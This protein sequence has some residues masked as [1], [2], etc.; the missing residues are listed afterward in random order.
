MKIVY[1]SNFINHYQIPLSDELYKLT[2]GHYWFIETQQMPDSFKKSGFP[3][4]DRPYI[5][6]AWESKQ[7][8]ERSFVLAV[9]ADVMIAGGGKYILP[10]ERKRLF[11]DKF[12]LEYGERPLKRGWINAFSPTNILT[13]LH[14]HLFFYHKPFYKL[15]VSAYTAND[16]YLQHSFK[17]RC[18]K[19]AYFPSIP[20]QDAEGILKK[21]QQGQK[22]R[23]I[24]CARFIPWKHPEMVVLLADKLRYAGYEFEINMI[25]SGELHEEIKKLIETKHLT[26]YVHLLG[27]FPNAEVME[28]MAEH[29]IFLFTS[30]KREGWGVV[31][32]EAMGQV[33]CP[34]ASH[35][36]G[37]VPFLLKDGE[38]GMV[39]ESCNLDSL[40]KKVCYLLDHPE[41]MQSMSKAAYHT[42]YQVWNPI[43]G[44]HRLYDFCRSFLEGKPQVYDEG[45][46]SR[47]F[48]MPTHL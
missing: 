48:P 21:K 4:Y 2:D 25:G 19:F 9:N 45:P 34:V 46:L 7:V 14:Y 24:W 23:L 26:E 33:C 31:L 1:V 30:D 12:T 44:A 10:Y 18:L 6:K 42:V 17:D 40:F 47:A 11:K 8:K 37:A 36:I 29:D 32:N 16:M 5:I 43:I 20:A 27:N 13:Q 22:P 28:M 39:F 38:N 41:E 35:L 3:E 15:C